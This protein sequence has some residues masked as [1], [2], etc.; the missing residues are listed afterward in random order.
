[1]KKAIYPILIPLLCLFSGSASFS[2]ERGDFFYPFPKQSHGLDLQT[3]TLIGFPRVY[4]VRKRDTIL[5]IARNFDL[6]FSEMQALYKD[7]DPWLPPEGWDLIIPTYWILPEMEEGGVIINLPE[8]RLYLLQKNKNR[9][10]TF[11][12]GIGVTEKVTPVG[13]FYVK[14]KKINPSWTIPPSLKEKYK[15][16]KKMPPG[17]N[18]PLG[19]R[20]IGLTSRYGIHGTNFPWAVGRLVTQGCIRLYPEDILRLYPLIS[21]GT[22]VKIIYEP[23]KI[24][25]KEGRIFIEVHEDIYQQIPDLYQYTLEKLQA[26]KVQNLVESEKL[27]QALDRRDGFPF[28]ITGHIKKR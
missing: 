12:I 22:P 3:D 25:F 11:P 7:F 15:G 8:M 10:G 16:I 13:Q 19:S 28:D 5:D 17:P 21:L 18:N 14:E 24:G 27:R 26:R 1:M 4:K 2:A 9:V 6:G 20:W 23:V